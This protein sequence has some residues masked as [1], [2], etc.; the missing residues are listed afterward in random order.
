MTRKST[1]MQKEKTYTFI[2]LFQNN[3]D[4]RKYNSHIQFKVQ[5]STK[6]LKT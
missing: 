4:P 1:G 3:I 5:E 2:Y 6:S